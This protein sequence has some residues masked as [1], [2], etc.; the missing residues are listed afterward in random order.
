MILTRGRYIEVC[1]ELPEGVE[2][3]VA[4]VTAEGDGL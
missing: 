4:S 2:R 1:S 3:P